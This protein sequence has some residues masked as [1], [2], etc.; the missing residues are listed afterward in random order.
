MPYSRSPQIHNIKSYEQFGH[1][2][3]DQSIIS[4]AFD[5]VDLL[6]NHRGK[7]KSL[8]DFFSTSLEVPSFSSADSSSAPQMPEA[9]GFSP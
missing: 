5:I 3:M 7:K 8:Q 1:Q 9:P 2:S 6:L 4:A